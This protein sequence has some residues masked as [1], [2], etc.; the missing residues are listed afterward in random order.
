[1]LLNSGG[2]GNLMYD[3]LLFIDDSETDVM[4]VMRTAEDVGVNEEVQAKF[5]K[6]III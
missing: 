3:E 6:I 4:C 1:M 2:S 5:I